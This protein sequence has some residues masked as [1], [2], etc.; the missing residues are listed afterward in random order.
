VTAK[1]HQAPRARRSHRQLRA[2]HWGPT[3]RPAE[4]AR[5]MDGGG[6]G[7]DRGAGG[8]RRV[9]A[10]PLAMLPPTGIRGRCG[11]LRIEFSGR[12]ALQGGRARRRGTSASSPLDASSPRSF[13]SPAAAGPRG[14]AAST[15]RARPIRAQ[16]KV[17]YRTWPKRTPSSG[18]LPL[19]AKVGI[20][21]AALALIGVAYWV[22][23]SATWRRN[24]R[25]VR[26][27]DQLKSDRAEAK[28]ARA[29]TKDRPSSTCG[30]SARPEIERRSS[31]RGPV[32]GLPELG[33]VGRD[34]ERGQP[35]RWTRTW[36]SSKEFYA[37]VPMKVRLTGRTPGRASSLQGIWSSIA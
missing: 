18:A 4:L 12:F 26:R 8:A 2:R 19:P 28:K 11:Y 1:L 37:R 15:A 24:H 6:R 35:H 17:K 23:F 33:P 29:R 7:P 34:P 25:R 36:S 3:T 13:D 10:R 5:I 31:Q 27:E 30:R 32:P 14:S 21:V 22:V 9:A 16:A 20:I